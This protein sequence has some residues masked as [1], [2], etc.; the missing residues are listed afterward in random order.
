LRRKLQS[1]TD[2]LSPFFLIVIILLVWQGLVSFSIVPNFML[3]SPVQVVQAFIDD[4]PSLMS[5]AATSLQETF[6]GMLIAVVLAFLSAFLMDRFRLVKKSLYPILILTQTIPTVAIAPLLVLWLGY[7]MTPKIVLVVISCYFPIAVG[8]LN[9][10]CSADPDVINLMR[11]M[12]STRWQIFCHVKI[13]SSLNNFFSGLRISVSYSV[14]GAVV[15][16]WLGGNSGLGVYMTRVRKSYAYDR[17]FA[18]ILLVSVISLVLMKLV[19]VVQ[20]LC[21]PWERS[22]R[23]A[24][25]A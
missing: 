17:M 4:F 19:D 11:T 14:I 23:E 20:R 16:E 15:A 6:Y 24:E 2:K 7:D 25:A 10:F 9:G 8:L 13:P 5:N 1:I 12:G 22:R 21:M 3:P 18:V